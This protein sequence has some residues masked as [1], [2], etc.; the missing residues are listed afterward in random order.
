MTSMV[1]VIILLFALGLVA[2]ILE[3]VLPFGISA[4]VGLV[5]M[6]VAGYLSIHEF[7][8]GRGSIYLIMAAG[9]SAA[10]VWVGVVW[11]RRYSQLKPL[12]RKTRPE[13]LESTAKEPALG[14]AAVVVQPLRP[15]GTIE[16]QGR[17]LM[18]RTLRVERIVEPGAT[19]LIRGRDSTFWIVDERPAEKPVGETANEKYPVPET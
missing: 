7:G 2:F 1:L 13:D 12:P 10:I 6:G 4:V 11:S 14:D 18:A 8:P 19:V 15:T 5:L 17:Q 3:I 9:V 16:W